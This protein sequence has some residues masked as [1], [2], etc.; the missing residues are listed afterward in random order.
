MHVVRMIGCRCSNDR[1][2]FVP[3]PYCEMVRRKFH[4][5]SA[6]AGIDGFMPLPQILCAVG[7]T[8]FVQSFIELS[9]DGQSY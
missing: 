4:G 6:D 7:L 8:A 2:L 3:L 5:I 9:E 1:D